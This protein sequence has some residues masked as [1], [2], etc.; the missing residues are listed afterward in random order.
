MSREGSKQKNTLLS[1]LT[2][3]PIVSICVSA[4]FKM[5]LQTDHKFEVKN[6]Q[7]GGMR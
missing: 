7:I 5:K 4:L 2:I 3:S 1:F 6:S